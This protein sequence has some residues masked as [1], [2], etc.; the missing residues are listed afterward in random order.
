MITAI[1]F[2]FILI[3]VVEGVLIAREFLG[4]R[5]NKNTHTAL[6]EAQSENRLLSE[7]LAA[8]EIK[9]EESRKELQGIHLLWNKALQ[10]EQKMRQDLEIA[11]TQLTYLAQTVLKIKSENK[12]Y[13]TEEETTAVIAGKKN[14]SLRAFKSSS[15]LIQRDFI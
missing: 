15:E 2:V 11:K 13:W 9:L 1:T 6:S 8:T 5:R 12:T 10:S 4:T 3:C 7:R 14:E